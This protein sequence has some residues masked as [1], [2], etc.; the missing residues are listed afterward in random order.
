MTRSTAEAPPAPVPLPA[1]SLPRRLA[2][3][4]TFLYLGL[5]ALPHLLGLIP[6]SERLAGLY[7]RLWQPLL[8][9]VAARLFH[10]LTPMAELP[11]GGGDTTTGFV[12]LFCMVAAVGALAL[13]WSLVDRRGRW[14]RQL[15]AGLRVYLRCALAY[16]L[17][18][19]GIA[20]LIKTQ[21][22]FPAPTRLGEVYGDASPLGL[23]WTFMGCSTPYN[24][25]TGLV[26]VGA[27][28]LLLF[29]RTATA[30]ALLAAAALTNVLVIDLAY[31]VTARSWAA[32]LLLMALVLLAPDLRRLADLLLFQRATTA[33]PLPER[34]P[35]PAWLQAGRRVC[36]AALIAGMVL[37][38]TA[39]RY[40]LWKRLDAL[41]PR[42]DRAAEHDYMVE[43]F[44]RHG[45]LVPAWPADPGRWQWLILSPPGATVVLSSFASLSGSYDAARQVL[46]LRGPG[47]EQLGELSCP[48]P[49]GDVL[50]ITG[51][52]GN[53]SVAV[54]LARLA[55]SRFLLPRRGFHWIEEA[56]F[57]R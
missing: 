35:G 18:F 32:H 39:E 19:Y 50:V 9:W 51:R 12:F 41:E 5:Y 36:K 44:V 23:L 33:A 53:D 42:R 14:D 38:I 45:R 46:T 54:T 6:G 56:P 24:V 30:G 2:C 52:L 13:A 17:L 43:A 16:A 29:R 27:G 37:S 4:F 34:R 31:E 48:P 49:A 55:P 11:E 22:V 28:W 3:R 25:F 10:L 20:K 7:F 47:R 26:E 57:D 1:R 21:F 40:T 15:Q 8:P